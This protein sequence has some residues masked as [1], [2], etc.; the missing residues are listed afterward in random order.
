MSRRRVFAAGVLGAA[1][2]ALPGPSITA[3]PSKSPAPPAGER[4]AE[5]GRDTGRSLY[6]QGR[7][8]VESEQYA[9]ARKIFERLAA[10]EPDDPDVLNLLAFTQRKTGDLDAAL[11]NYRRALDR[12]PK[13][14]EA[15]EYLGEAYLQAALREAETLRGYGDAGAE[16]LRQLA[17][18]FQEAAS[19]C[20]ETAQGKSGGTAHRKW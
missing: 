9:D 4:P 6:E 14:P 1:L 20:E 8:L 11:A 12:R 7:L 10:Q 16:A 19:H 5:P 18:A 13:F 17:D 3:L 2:A 15:R